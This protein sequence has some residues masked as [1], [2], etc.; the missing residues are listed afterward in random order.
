LTRK[1]FCRFFS[2]F[3]SSSTAYAIYEAIFSWHLAIVV[4]LKA[5]AFAQFSAASA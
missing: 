5:S 1:P 3:P 4:A 2:A